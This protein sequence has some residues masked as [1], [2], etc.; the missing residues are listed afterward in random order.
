MQELFLAVSALPRARGRS[1]IHG[2]RAAKFSARERTGFAALST[3]LSEDAPMRSSVLA[4][5][6]LGQPPQATRQMTRSEWQSVA[7]CG[8]GRGSRVPGRGGA[9]NGV[10]SALAAPV[11]AQPRHCA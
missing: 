10:V 11:V 1:Q 7:E 6:L 9:G 8:P 3:S 5:R 4:S 2:R